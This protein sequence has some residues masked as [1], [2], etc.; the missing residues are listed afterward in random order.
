L[1]LV[2]AQDTALKPVAT[3]LNGFSRV[4]PYFIA[5]SKMEW[6]LNTKG[7]IEKNH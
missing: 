2:S 3:T 7:A 5:L 6:Y 1:C 4:I